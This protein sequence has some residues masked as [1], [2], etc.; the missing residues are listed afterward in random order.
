MKRA[1]GGGGGGGD[2][3]EARSQ[4]GV[5]DREGRL[6]PASAREKR[7][8]GLRAVRLESLWEFVGQ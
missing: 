2:R 3:R 1:K 4:E 8:Q 5:R 7:D 6:A